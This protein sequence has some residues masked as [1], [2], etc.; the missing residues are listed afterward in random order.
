MLAHAPAEFID[1]THFDSVRF[2]PPDWA[3]ESFTAAAR[4]G[5]LAYTGYRGNR[6]VLKSVA[7][8]LE[9]FTGLG[10]DPDAELILTPGTQA[11][12]FGALAALV[13]ESDPVL[14]MDPDYLFSERILRFLGAR[15]LSV[16][17]MP[18]QGLQPDLDLLESTLQRL[19]PQL[20]LFSHPNNPTG[21]VYSPA[22]IKRIAELAVEHDLWVVVDELYAR[23]VYGGKPYTH[24]AAQPGMRE[25][26]VTLF[27]PSKT[28]S[29]SGYQLVW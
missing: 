29:L 15:V 4:D 3:L 8:A 12:L 19:H 25:R 7:Q 23:L 13:N 17:L 10:F 14:L 27:G 9:A 16:P 6:H 24:L 5:A 20:L 11:G 18:D 21:A 2:P 28:E 1:T 22:V 26:T